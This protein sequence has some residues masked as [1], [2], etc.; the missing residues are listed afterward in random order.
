MKR[1]DILENIE[2]TDAGAKGIAVGR[3]ENRV[4]FIEG[5]VPGDIV[6]VR[7]FRV[8]SNF[9]EGKMQTLKQA[10]PNRVE[11]VCEHFGI[12][13]GC[14]WQSLDYQQQLFF[15]EKEIREALSRIAKIQPKNFHPIVRSEAIY[16]Y[17]N[18]LEFTFGARPWHTQPFVED[19]PKAP[20]HSLGFHVPG[21]FDKILDITNCYLQAEPSN[22]IRLWFRKR[23]IDSGLPFYDQKDNSGFFR[24]L[25]VRTTP[26]GETMV[27]LVVNDNEKGKVLDIMRDFV[28]AF[29]D[30]TSTY[31]ALNTKVNDS[32]LDVP[33]FLYH[34][35]EYITE[36]MDETYY[37]I[38]PLSFFQTNSV[39]AGN[40]YKHI[41]TLA[42]LTGSEN[43][44]DLYTGAGTIANYLAADAKKIVGVEYV[45]DAV[46]DAYENAKLNGH[47]NLHFVAG[48]MAKV[49]RPSFYREH[50]RPDLVITDPPR[51]GMHLS[52]TESLRDCG[53][54]KI[55]YVSCNPATQA[56][57]IAILAENYDLSDVLPIDMFPHTWHVENIALLIRK[58]T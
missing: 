18:K 17:R 53:A 2:I 10:S 35:K 41:K 4:I 1:G 32:M 39:Q 57:D 20:P 25:I 54:E 42:G 34:G 23:A 52:V 44:Y 3:H 19:A 58:K 14:R 33:V 9:A 30:V 55:V 16:N 43:V 8:K 27:I 15:K 50:G 22:S 37:R 36:I 29:P 28:T 26:N 12:C 6:D 56:R 31:Y 11:P 21:R 46:R 40:M 13:G 45:A 51:A 5:A 24:N 7:L 49:L 38:G 48:D 47:K